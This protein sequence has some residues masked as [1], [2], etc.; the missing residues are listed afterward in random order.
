MADSSNRPN[1]KGPKSKGQKVKADTQQKVPL[2][3]TIC[4]D[5]T[6]EASENSVG[7]DAVF[8]ATVYVRPGFTG[9]ALACPP[10]VSQL[11]EVQKN[12]FSVHTAN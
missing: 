11:S 4:E 6:E 3:C 2:C 10:I 5:A 8:F 7:E 12:P 1:A 9:A